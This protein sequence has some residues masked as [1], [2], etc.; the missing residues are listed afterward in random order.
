MAQPGSFYGLLTRRVGDARLKA[1]LPH[2]PTGGTGRV[3]DVGCGLTDLA[4]R[5][6]DYVGCDRNADVLAAAAEEISGE[7]FL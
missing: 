3:L 6:A 5:I 2:L 7:R 1:A 4:A